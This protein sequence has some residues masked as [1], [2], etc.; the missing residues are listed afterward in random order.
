[1]RLQSISLRNG[2]SEDFGGYGPA[3]LETIIWQPGTG[4]HSSHYEGLSRLHRPARLDD[5]HQ[6]LLR[7]YGICC[8]HLRCARSP[9]CHRYMRSVTGLSPVAGGAQAGRS[10][11]RPPRAG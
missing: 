10:S 7:R 9:V 5:Q 3:S 1:L 2:C 6:R 4:Q 11:Y 8:G